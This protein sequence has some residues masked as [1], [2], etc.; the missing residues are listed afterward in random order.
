MNHRHDDLLEIM[1]AVEFPGFAFPGRSFTRNAY[2]L[3]VARSAEFASML[4]VR[5][6][7]FLLLHSCS[8]VSS[9][10]WRKR[11]SSS[12]LGHLINTLSIAT[13]SHHH[14]PP[15]Q[16]QSNTTA[17]TSANLHPPSTSISSTAPNSQSGPKP[18]PTSSTAPS[19]P[20][21]G[22]SSATA[23]ARPW[24]QGRM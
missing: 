20:S 6:K 22:T 5:E 11:C 2:R 21:T 12:R 1:V 8:F 13:T 4:D 23:T 17:S 16:R 9:T 3:S 7:V 24:H 15:S 10:G 18:S 14:P 19:T